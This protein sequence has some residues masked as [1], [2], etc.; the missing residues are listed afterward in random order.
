[1]TEDKPEAAEETEH[2]QEDETISAETQVTETL[3][4]NVE[5]DSEVPKEAV[6]DTLDNSLVEENKVQEQGNKSYYES[7]EALYFML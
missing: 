2:V 6:M 4:E 1:M 7:F 5:A 3:E